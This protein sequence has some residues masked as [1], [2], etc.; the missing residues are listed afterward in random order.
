MNEFE[1]TQRATVA[2]ALAKTP[3]GIRVLAFEETGEELADKI[4]FDL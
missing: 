4:A 2:T 3:T 1:A